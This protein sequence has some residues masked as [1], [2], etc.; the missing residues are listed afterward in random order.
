MLT[1]FRLWLFVRLATRTVERSLRTYRAHRSDYQTKRPGRR[2]GF[3]WGGGH[4]YED[5]KWVEL[6]A[7]K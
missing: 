6:P 5:G 3:K 7:V 2:D 4:L 1:R